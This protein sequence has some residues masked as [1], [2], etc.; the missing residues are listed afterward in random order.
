M[1]QTSIENEGFE[2]LENVITTRLF[3]DL[4]IISKYYIERAIKRQNGSGNVGLNLFRTENLLYD[5][6]LPDLINNDVVYNI[7]KRVLGERF[8]LNEIYIYFSLPNNTIQ[9]LHKDGIE[10][11]PESNL[12]T[13]PYFLAVQYPLVDFNSN[14]GGTRI[15]SGSHLLNEKPT[16]LE[17]ENL[18]ILENI[19]PEIKKRGCMVRNP[20][21]WHGAGVN[22]TE[23]TRAMITLSFSKEW[24]GNKAKVSKDLYF[25][26]DKNKRHLLTTD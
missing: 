16:R 10:L 26:I 2:V 18:L 11:F 5:F 22:Q 6:P 21:T 19:T 9:E 1:K 25:C 4:E 13:P 24:F 20:Q 7:I 15:I 8:N 23:Q 17:N 14:S 3:K 12:K